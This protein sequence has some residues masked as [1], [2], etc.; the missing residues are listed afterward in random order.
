LLVS[1]PDAAGNRTFLE[2]NDVNGGPTEYSAELIRAALGPATGS[3]FLATDTYVHNSGDVVPIAH[4]M[5][6]MAIWG[7]STFG[8]GFGY[9]AAPFQA[10]GVT[11]YSGGK[12]GEQA[13]HIGARLGSTPALLTVT[14]GSIPASG[15][16]T[17][18][19][20]NMTASSWLKPYTGWL[21]GVH[22]TLSSTDTVI[23]FTRTASGTATA[24]TAG[25]KFM[26]EEGEAHRSD[27]TLLNTGKNDLNIGASAESVIALTD[28]AHDY[29]GPLAK[30]VIVVGHFMSQ[31]VPAGNEM[32]TRLKAIHAAHAKRYG[33]RFVDMG[34]YLSSAQVWTDTGITPTLA[35]LD[36]QS[37][38]NK[39]PSLTPPGDPAHLNAAGYTA[40]ANLIKARA[41]ALG[42]Y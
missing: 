20:S 5:T 36:E 11:V 24:V 29:I 37:W 38:G 27:V 19:A 13:T 9:F 17:V 14:G 2:A 39:P 22:G 1:I 28:A 41:V 34:A 25:L 35:D 32:H 18:T 15:A 8:S 26:P 23:T 4:D 3:D 33:P 42:W 21:A 30:R 6:R 40:V 31:G 7:S 12:M 10:E 16:V